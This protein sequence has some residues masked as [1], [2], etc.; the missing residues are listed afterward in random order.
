MILRDLYECYETMAS[1][2]DESIPRSGWTKKSVSWLL[3]LDTDGSVVAC[4]PLVDDSGKKP[5]QAFVPAG[6]RSSGIKAFFL[7]D[8]REYVFGDDQKKGAEKHAAISELHHAVLDGVDDVGARALCAFFDNH[9]NIEELQDKAAFRDFLAASSK[10]NIIFGL[11][12]ESEPIHNRA[13]I[14]KAWD[15][16]NSAD[17][18]ERTVCLVSG[19]QGV[20]KAGLFPL[21]T[22]LPGAQSSGASLVGA[23]N[24]AF[25]SYGIKQGEI[26]AISAEAAD[27]SSIAL[28]F[29]TKDPSHRCMFGKD[30]VVFWADKN[31]S[32]NQDFIALLMDSE[33]ISDQ[34]AFIKSHGED[35]GK[36]KAI[37]HALQRIKAGKA[38]DA[39]D[40]GCGYHLLGIAPYQARL[41]VRFYETGTLGDLEVS[42]RQFFTDTDMVDVEPCSIMSY[43]EQV[44]PLGKKD[45][46]PSTLIGAVM[47]AYIANLPFPRMLFDQLIQ[48][49]RVDHG[50]RNRW[51]M[52]RRSAMLKACL[53]REARRR[54]DIATERS[55]T[56]SLNTENTNEGYLLGRLFA[57][58]EKAQLEAIKGANAT[59][60][61]RFMGAAA[62]TPARVFPQLMRLAQHHISKSDYGTSIDRKI[63]EVIAMLGSNGFPK[64]LGYDD[65][66]LFFI[67]YYQQKRALYTSTEHGPQST[68]ESESNE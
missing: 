61:D 23:N 19:K 63:E 10:D 48:R 28:S 16:Y 13:A 7:C 31:E 55:L 41:A 50:V 14:G 36:R 5:L 67:G 32:V 25:R 24:E 49:T 59:I 22:G 52:G 35:L 43:V 42:A 12:G 39:V 4:A 47:K 38:F 40:R 37:Q 54:G 30:L 20:A 2:G 27:K 65:Q 11:S 17:D 33:H 15:E 1:V 56:V 57:I 29:L 26:G 58:L 68:G 60:R 66:G 44:A 64:T 21:V 18:G 46:I 8:N 6:Q 62:S 53:L 34:N 9:S 45:N 3:T 51:D